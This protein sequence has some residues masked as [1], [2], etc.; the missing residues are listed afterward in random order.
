M[1]SFF[2]V[3]KFEFSNYLQ[4]KIYVVTTVLVTLLFA[5]L[6]CI[7]TIISIFDDDD[8]ATPEPAAPG[9]SSDA[10]SDSEATNY[11]DIYALYDPS[12]LITDFTSFKIAFE[13]EWINVSSEADLQKKLEN[14]EIEGGFSLI[15]PTEAKLFV[16][17]SGMYE[18]RD[19]MFKEIFLTMYR[20]NAL[21]ELGIDTT[22][23]DPYYNMYMSI[24]TVAL[25]KDG[26]AGYMYAYVLLFIL[27]FMILMYG[28]MIATSVTTEKS[29]RTIEVLVTSTSTNALLA[30]K[31]LA[32]TVASVLQ[33]GIMVG[34][35]L[36]SY[37]ANRAAWKELISFNFDI[38]TNLIIAFAVY[39]VL[40]YVFYAFIYGM[41]GA[42]VSKTEDIGKSTGPL[43]M[44]FMIGFLVTV[45]SASVP[46]SIWMKVMSHIP[47]TSCNAMVVRIAI[48]NVGFVEVLISVLILIASNVAIA[49]IASKIY[50][51]TTLMYGNPIKLSNALKFL[52]KE[53]A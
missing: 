53:K 39:G 13:A 19:V 31:V 4:N 43:Q 23:V 7:P 45:Y 11:E 16:A 44:I 6:M 34:G 9:I 35:A 2:K 14:G 51:M 36:L 46:D 38:P 15:S 50:R 30:G 29:S 47:F 52:K 10:A 28:S 24:E 48:G 32:G 33:A 26:F 42:L 25:E 41:L 37:S 21:A 8:N 27:Y 3:F 17:E 1:R 20:E 49:I 22:V 5:A 40:G 12:G 18:S